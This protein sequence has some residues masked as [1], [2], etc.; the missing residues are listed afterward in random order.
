MRAGSLTRPSPL[1]AFDCGSQS[2]SSVSTF[3]AAMDEA[4]LMAVVVLPTPPFWLATAMTRPILFSEESERRLQNKTN[5]CSFAMTD[6]GATV[7]QGH[8]VGPLVGYRQ[9][10]A[11]FPQKCSTWNTCG[12]NV[13]EC[14]TWNITRS[15][16]RGTFL[17]FSFGDLGLGYSR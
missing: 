11:I 1:V 12:R 2:T 16:P 13:I 7:P 6:F 10:R 3:A 8:S 14:S 9:G 5:R 4:R 17:L 15:V